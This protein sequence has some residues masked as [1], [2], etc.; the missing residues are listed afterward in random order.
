[1]NVNDVL[2]A[3]AEYDHVHE[4][5]SIGPA[6]VLVLERDAPLRLAL[7]YSTEGEF[8]AL[9]DSA[10]NEPR[11]VELLDLFFALRADEEGIE[12]ADLWAREAAHTDR[13]ASGERLMNPRVTDS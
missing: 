3:K 12:H 7:V 9:K 10:R 8:E 5:R 1:M 6:I 4:V 11:W 13:L 2:S